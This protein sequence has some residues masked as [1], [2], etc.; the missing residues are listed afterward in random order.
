VK[1]DDAGVCCAVCLGMGILLFGAAPAAWAAGTSTQPSP[2]VV[3]ATPGAKQVSLSVCAGQACGE[4]SH[5]VVVLDP[6]PLVVSAGSPV[7]AAEVG[8]LVRLNGAGTGR[9]P[10][11][12][13]WSATPVTG[14]A[15]SV[16]GATGWWNTTGLAPG[17]YAVRL[18]IANTAG[19]AVSLPFSVTLAP[20]QAADY[21]TVSPCRVYDSRSGAALAAGSSGVLPVAAASCGVPSDAR[22][23]ALNVTVVDPTGQGYAALFPG[24]YPQPSTSTINFTAG[25][26]R[27]NAV[28]MPLSTDGIGT[29]GLALVMAG[30]GS[31]HVLV[32]VAGYFRPGA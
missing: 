14:P 20:A 1:R 29:L 32:D 10:L 5:S 16:S 6:H 25:V 3:F 13:T 19:N 8:Q 24:N 23:V 21:Y 27:A 11:D 26:T 7:T 17:V 31:S 18:T 22:A 28:I 15:Q 4:T 30:G 12:Y 2:S 9:P